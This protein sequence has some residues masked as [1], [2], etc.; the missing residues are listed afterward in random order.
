MT[1]SNE[2]STDSRQFR[3][4][5]IYRVER[6]LL[7]TAWYVSYQVVA[8]NQNIDYTL[9]CTK[10]S[11]SVEQKKSLQHAARILDTVDSPH[12]V[13][14]FDVGIERS[15]IFLVIEKLRGFALNDWVLKREEAVDEFTALRFF[16]QLIL[17]VKDLE[18]YQIIH[19]NIK[20]SSIYVSQSQ[21]GG[22]DFSLKLW[23]LALADSGDNTIA[24]QAPEK[25][26]GDALS[27][28]TDIYGAA[29]VIYWLLTGRLL[30]EIRDMGPLAVKIMSLNKEDHPLSLSQLRPEISKATASLIEGCLQKDPA[31]RVGSAG[32]LLNQIE[33]LLGGQYDPG[34]YLHRL[35]EL[36]AKRGDFRET[37]RLGKQAAQYPGASQK[38]KP[39][40]RESLKRQQEKEAAHFKHLLRNIAGLV[41]EHQLDVAKTRLK[42]TATQVQ[43]NEYLHDSVKAELRAQLA[44]LQNAIAIGGRFKPAY[45][46]LTKNGQRYP[47]QVSTVTV[48]RTASIEPNLK[49][50]NLGAEDR[51]V[52][53]RHAQFV[54]DKGVWKL[55]HLESA[56]NKTFINQREVSAQDEVNIQ[57]GDKI[58]FGRLEVTF[59][60]QGAE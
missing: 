31:L 41:S 19:G 44:D 39:L 10:D 2:L 27:V 34:D 15:R 47:L 38:L 59:H 32:E 60:V 30:Y 11:Y 46:V 28:R 35:A 8:E 36:A 17:A 29:A 12:I 54:F 4:N 5:D 50:I 43:S 25:V 24:F 3:G 56:S 14:A 42:E 52:S 13:K 23:D 48:V 53:R 18:F 45:L 40:L 33:R 1:T 55:R 37:I 49:E 7:E 51:S 58:Q 57:S 20:P 6:K 16:R 9:I 26:S 22:D 21:Q